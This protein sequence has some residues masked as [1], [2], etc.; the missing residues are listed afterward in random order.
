MEERV[1][2]DVPANGAF[3]IIDAGR[4]DAGT[5]YATLIAPQDVQPVHLP[6]ARRRRDVAENRQRSSRH[7]V[8]ARRPRGYRAQGSAVLRHRERDV[9]C[10]STPATTG[11]AFSS[12]CRASSMRDLW[13]MATTWC[14]AP[15][16]VRLWILDNIT[17][18]R[19]LGIRPRHRRPPAV[20]TRAGDSGP[21]GCQWRHAVAGGSSPTAPNPPEGAIID[22]R[23]PVVPDGELTLTITRRARGVVRTF[24]STAPPAST[25]LANVP[26]YWFAPPVGA[27][28]EPRTES[29]RWNLRYPN[30]KILPFG[31]FG[32][33]LTSSVHARRPRDP[34]P[35]A[36]RP[37]RGAARG[38]GPIHGHVDGGRQDRAPNTDHHSPIRARGHPRPIS[39]RSSPSPRVSPMRSPRPTT[40]FC[41]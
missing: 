35:H 10:R 13:F 37:A 33:L 14:S 11:R 39:S 28:E 3:E 9:S 23:L 38:P 2:P 18:L 29:F 27:H 17:P 32:G 20:R 22:Y 19:Q 4:H 16:A 8:R 5:A 31:Y 34:R 41:R 30:P 26:E 36:A 6:H 15:T 25:L 12:T 21:V 24:T 40:A 7:G 1:A